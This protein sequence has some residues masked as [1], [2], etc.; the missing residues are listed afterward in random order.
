MEFKPVRLTCYPILTVVSSVDQVRYWSH[1][2]CWL[3]LLPPGS[4]V[5][6]PFV[7]PH[8]IPLVGGLW[9]LGSPPNRQNISSISFSSL[10]MVRIAGQTVETPKP[11]Y[12]GHLRILDKTNHPGIIRV[13]AFKPSKHLV[14]MKED[15]CL[16]VKPVVT[17]LV[18]QKGRTQVRRNDMQVYMVHARK[19]MES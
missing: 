13:L 14:Q 8:P 6:Q 15:S 3:L 7:S 17:L 5:K 12:Q 11:G 4:F 2:E 9:T 19:C 10:A 16:G 1:L 18:A